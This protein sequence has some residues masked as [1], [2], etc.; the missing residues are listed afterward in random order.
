MSIVILG[1]GVSGLSIAYFLKQQGIPSLVLEK[2]T[3]IVVVLRA[4][5]TG[6]V[7]GVTSRHIGSTLIVEKFSIVSEISPH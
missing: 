3:H 6:T 4:V 5:F 2:K 7:S 1:A